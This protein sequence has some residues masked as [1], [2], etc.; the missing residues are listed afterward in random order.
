MN[1]GKKFVSLFLVF[2]LLALY[3]NLYAKKKGAELI[4]RKKD[5]QKIKGELIAV[6]E[7]SLLMLVSG[8]DVSA[9]ISDINVI[10]IV[11][12]SK[13]LMGSLI[14][15]ISG[16][17]VGYL[18]PL[19]IYSEPP[20]GKIDLFG[21]EYGAKCGATIG[22]ILGTVIGAGIGDAAGKNIR[23]QIEGWPD[24][25]VKEVLEK[26]RSKARIPDYQ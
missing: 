26:L 21:P 16:A 23:I 18:I 15:L 2:S 14:G 8:V 3:G 6:K 25:E 22:G 19:I 1:K 9:D 10:E 12:K 4:V 7:S 11:K 17:G 5:G 20:P 13:T 24:T